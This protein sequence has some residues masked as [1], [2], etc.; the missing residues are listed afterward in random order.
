MSKELT[1]TS[2]A[3]LGLLAVKPWT[4]YE[5]A[6]QIDVAMARFWPRARSKVYE[7]PK[8]LVA[9]GLARSADDPVGKRPRTVYAITPK[10][11]RALARWLDDPAAGPVIE[12]EVLLKVFVGTYGSKTALLSTIRSARAWAVEKASDDV[13]IGERYLS[14]Q[15][16]FADRTAQNMLVGRFLADFVD[17]VDRWSVWAEQTVESW[18]TQISRAE[19]DMALLRRL[20]NRSRALAQRATRSA[21]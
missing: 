4:S 15:S 9:L 21:E 16:E 7:E 2:F 10:G 12:F 5:L 6:K 8:K 13:L 17:L 3:V 18:P 20:T 19:P 1:S 14:G 11:R